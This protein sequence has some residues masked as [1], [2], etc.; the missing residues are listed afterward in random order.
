M[1][2]DLCKDLN[3]I[4]TSGDKSIIKFLERYIERRTYG[5]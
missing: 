4:E 1:S 3:L 5:A 2:R